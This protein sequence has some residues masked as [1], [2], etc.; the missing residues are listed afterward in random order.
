MRE[1]RSSY[2]LDLT[3]LDHG[4]P[5][6][7]PVR[8]HTD[9]QWL[10]SQL[11]MSLNVDSEDVANASVILTPDN[12][13]KSPSGSLIETSSKRPR[14]P[15]PPSSLS[16]VVWTHVVELTLERD[17]QYNWDLEHHQLF[18]NQEDEF[19][20]ALKLLGKAKDEYVLIGTGYVRCLSEARAGL[21][22]TCVCWPLATL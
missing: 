9:L 19:D 6:S 3:E 21:Y 5:K 11:R 20:S 13:R 2:A 15:S 18:Q 22:K 8:K 7:A 17:S 16:A 1:T 12:K 10:T 4:N 14:L